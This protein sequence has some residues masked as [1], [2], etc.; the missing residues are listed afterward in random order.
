MRTACF[1]TDRLLH[2]ELITVKEVGAEL[3]LKDA[4]SKISHIIVCGVCSN[5]TFFYAISESL[6]DIIKLYLS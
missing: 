5:S 4:E 6:N 3:S 1:H 2:V